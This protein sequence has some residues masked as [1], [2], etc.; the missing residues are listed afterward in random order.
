MS[1]LDTRYT[2]HSARVGE[3]VK[4]NLA[5]N[6]LQTQATSQPVSQATTQQHFSHRS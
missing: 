4:L 2:T 6:K 5:V 1:H 3:G